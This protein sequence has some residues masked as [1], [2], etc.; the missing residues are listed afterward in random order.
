MELS[1]VNL[2][3]AAEALE[4]HWS[5]RVVA[6]VADQYVKVA[7]VLG[8]L[9]WHAHQGQ[10]ELFLVLRGSLRIQ[11]EEGEVTLGPGD[12]FVVPA[13]VRHNP[14]AEEECWLALVEPAETE[15]ARRNLGRTPIRQTPKR[16]M[17]NARNP[18]RVQ[19]RPLTS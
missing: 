12:V 2:E 10:D 18:G 6:R 3:A 13:G 11:M 19:S 17:N 14:V 1:V 9:V 4:E 16:Y 15:H 5:P 7:K 8:E